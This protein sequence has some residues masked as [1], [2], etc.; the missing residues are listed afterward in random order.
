MATS[1]KMVVDPEKCDLC[2]SCLTM[3]PFRT[4]T[5]E[6]KA[7]KIDMEKCEFC[8]FCTEVCKTEAIALQGLLVQKRRFLRG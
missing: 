5:I 6:D 8:L 4:I 3:C 7:V 1:S 2:G